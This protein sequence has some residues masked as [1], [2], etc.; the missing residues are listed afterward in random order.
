MKLL[1]LLATWATSATTFAADGGFLFV[2]FKGEATPM[3]EQIYFATSEEGQRWDA[4]NGE[5]PLLVSKLGEKGVRDPFIIRSPDGGKIYLIA[6]DLSI[7]L[8][9]NWGRAVTAGSKSLVVWEST[10]LVKWSEPR[11]V[12]VAA[13][14]AGCTWAPEAFY[15]VETKDYL[16]FWASKTR[17]DNFGKHRIWACRTK[18][19][20]TFGEPFIY[21]ERES[22]IID[23]TIVEENGVYYRFSK[24]E[25]SKATLMESSAKLMGPWKEM[26]DFSLN[27]LVGYE[28][29]TC[30]PVKPA[31]A[32]KGATW[33]LLLDYYSK[34]EG[35]KPFVSTDLAAGKFRTGPGFRFPYRFRHGSVLA[36]TTAE[37]KALK[38]AYG[39]A[40]KKGT[41][42][43]D[44]EK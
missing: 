29:P 43:K 15:D 37:L 10:D 22:D 18:D 1:L 30:F 5:E 13:D 7:H 33:C 25:S 19:F 42:L 8:N 34:G 40:P 36:I 32:G 16:V 39:K 9:G 35:Y 44:R 17:S 11:L 14:D 24:D 38:D 6:T 31:A 3:T 2:T 12:K 4:L 28:G 27:K 20:T 21:I 26:A 23:T 41:R